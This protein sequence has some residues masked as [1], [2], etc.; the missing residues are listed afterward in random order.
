MFFAGGG[1][2][3]RNC[4]TLLLRSGSGGRCGAAAAAAS[5]AARAGSPVVRKLADLTHRQR[6]RGGGGRGG[7]ADGGSAR[8]GGVGGGAAGARAGR[9]YEPRR[10]GNDGNSAPHSPAPRFQ[11]FGRA[12]GEGARVA[13]SL[14]RDFGMDGL[15]PYSPETADER[16]AVLKW[17]EG[18]IRMSARG[19]ADMA[20]QEPRIA[21]QDTEAI[22]ARLAW[23]R[24]RLRLSDEQI[25][26][27]V[28]RR[29][30][31]LC[32]SVEDGME[33]KVWIRAGGWCPPAG[34]YPFALPAPACRN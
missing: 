11:P 34:G 15:K 9:T 32:R 5:R 6:G 7:G 18:A 31:V 27:L 24:E 19:V 3:A 10:R 21:E 30:S 2:S 33:P 22:S 1:S 23:L 29:S 13:E 25:R 12:G 26:S 28:H 20:E 16:K 17:L 4:A 8:R 14:H